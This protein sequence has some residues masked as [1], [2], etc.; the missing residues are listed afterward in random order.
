MNNLAVIYSVDNNEIHTDVFMN[1]E[2]SLNK[3]RVLKENWKELDLFELSDLKDIILK[4][5]ATKY[6]IMY[7]YNTV[8]IHKYTCLMDYIIEQKIPIDKLTTYMSDKGTLNIIINKSDSISLLGGDT[9]TLEDTNFVKEKYINKGILNDLVFEM[10]YNWFK[11][12]EHIDRKK[13]IHKVLEK[14][15]ALYQN[16]FINKRKEVYDILSKLNIPENY[17]DTI[18]NANAISNINITRSKLN[19]LNLINEDTNSIIRKIIQQLDISLSRATDACSFCCSTRDKR[20]L[21][22]DN[23]RLEETN[24]IPE[25]EYYTVLLEVPFYQSINLRHLDNLLGRCNID[26]I[27]LDHDCKDTELKKKLIYK[28]MSID[29]QLRCHTPSREHEVILNNIYK[30]IKLLRTK[31]IYITNVD[32]LTINIKVKQTINKDTAVSIILD[33]FEKCSLQNRICRLHILKANEQRSTLREHS[34]N[35]IILNK[36]QRW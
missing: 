32:N 29:K 8:D 34:D 23:P 4:G 30:L 25:D 10:Q 11:V 33:A 16:E 28:I 12:R 22:Y 21:F 13:L 26:N 2:K 5:E 6:I 35:C 17:L 31:D 1:T 18:E 24:I 15:T 27:R 20:F 3:R 14:N 19:K 36:G 7:P 9:L